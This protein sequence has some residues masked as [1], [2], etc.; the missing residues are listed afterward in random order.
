MEALVISCVS[1]VR[2]EMSAVQWHPACEVSLV[3]QRRQN[4]FSSQMAASAV[5][6]SGQ[7]SQ[8]E[9]TSCLLGEDHITFSYQCP[10]IAL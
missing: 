4:L 5:D 6:L 1:V 9:I 8:C 2:H 7:S 3:W 10:N